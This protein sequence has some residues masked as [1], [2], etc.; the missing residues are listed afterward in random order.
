MT[1]DTT[2]NCSIC[3]ARAKE[4]VALETALAVKDEALR[5][6]LDMQPTM[7]THVIEVVEIAKAALSSAP[8]DK[9]LVDVS[10]LDDLSSQASHGNLYH[11]HA[12]ESCAGIAG[13]IQKLLGEGGEDGA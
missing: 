12:P 7:A 6:I 13:K 8:T 9:V 1:F 10:W 2:N 3:E 4:L 5:T 11:A